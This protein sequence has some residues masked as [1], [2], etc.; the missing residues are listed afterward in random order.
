MGFVR[1]AAAIALVLGCTACSLLAPSREELSGGKTSSVDAETMVVTEAGLTPD[2]AGDTGDGEAAIEEAPADAT[3]PGDAGMDAP[4]TVLG[5]G[6]LKGIG[7]WESITPPDLILSCPAGT[8]FCANFGPEAFVLDPQNAGTLYLGTSG[9]G[10]YKSTDCGSTWKQ[11]NTGT[12]STTLSAGSQRIFEI[13]PVDSKILYTKGNSNAAFK[14]TNGGVDWQKI[15]PP[16][17]PVLS[18]I[19]DYNA[20]GYL[21]IFPGEHEHLVLTFYGACHKQYPPV[22]F[23]ETKDGGATWNMIAGRPE[24]KSSGS[25]K[26]WFLDTSTWLY[27][28]GDDG[29]WRSSD[30][31]VTWQQL[32]DK[33]VGEPMGRLFQAADGTWYLGSQSGILRSRDGS[34]WTLVTGTQWVNGG[35]VSDGTSLFASSF[36]LC[37]EHGTDLQFYA[38]SPETDGRTWTQFKAPGMTQGGFD[39]GYDRPH[40]LYYSSNC[41]AGLWRVVTY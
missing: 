8:G 15:W 21:R 32:A 22:C 14:S 3:A 35:I 28:S 11:I 18:T 27:G 34:V 26:L 17:D 39:V 4:V 24:W 30:K 33:S 41:R 10:I 5:C 40:H 9:Q 25:V 13:D 38:T 31:G 36:G 2:D 23:A 7:E 16:D 12:N 6:S 29:L 1:S 37:D 20:V 19:V